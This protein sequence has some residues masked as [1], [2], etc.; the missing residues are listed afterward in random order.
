MERCL[1]TAYN[2][3]SGISFQALSRSKPS[4]I[5]QNCQENQLEETTNDRFL[6]VLK[7]PNGFLK[8]AEKKSNNTE[9]SIFERTHSFDKRLPA[10]NGVRIQVRNQQ[11][12]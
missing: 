5:F 10:S 8:G 12:I 3:I 11:L 1:P 4:R 9:E 2:H 6:R 7:V